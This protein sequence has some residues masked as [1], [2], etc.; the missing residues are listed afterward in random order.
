MR[1]NRKGAKDAK[2]MQE[3]FNRKD[4]KSAKE[5]QDLFNRKGAKNAKNNVYIL[6]NWGNGYL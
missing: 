2:E 5:I 1:I 6:K 4:A 3:L